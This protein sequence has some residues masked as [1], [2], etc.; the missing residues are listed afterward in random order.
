MVKI[1][2]RTGKT[3][4]Q[5]DKLKLIREDLATKTIAALNAGSAENQASR[6]ARES[7]LPYI[8]LH[9]FPVDHDDVLV[10]PEEDARRLGFACF[11]KKGVNLRI[12]LL[13]PD[14][15]KAKA[16]VQSFAD[17]RKLVPRYYVASQSSIERTWSTYKKH[18]LL[19]VLEAYKIS[20][21]GD[22]LTQFEK[23]FGGLMAIRKGIDDMPT[24]EA[25]QTLLTGAIKFQASDVHFEPE[26][27]QKVRIRYRIDGV[28]QDI[29]RI[30]MHL[31]PLILSRVKMMGKMK[32]N[33][34]DSAQDGRFSIFFNEER[35]DVRVSII[36]GNHGE[37]IVMRLLSQKGTALDVEVLG[38]TGL[39]YE[40]VRK[41]IAK[42]NGLIMTTGPTGSGKTTTLYALLNKLNDTK[43]KIITIEDPIE[44]QIDGISQ[45]EVSKGQAY[46]FAKGLRSI[47][48]QD[49][50][51]ILVGEIRDDETADIAINA[52]LTGHLVLSTL[53]TN[54]A[55]GAIP[56][57]VEMGVKPT[58]IAPAVNAFMA[59][60]LVRQLCKHCKT[61]YEPAKETID[62]LKEILSLISPKA[63]VEVPND[64]KVL[65][66]SNGCDQCNHTG[67]KG[68]IGIFEVL[69]INENIEKL[70]VELGGENDITRVALED[71]MVTM[72]QDGILKAITGITS[73]EE[74]WRV[75]GEGEFLK[76]IYEKLMEQT[77]ARSFTIDTETIQEVEQTMASGKSFEYRTNASNET[78]RRIFASAALSNAGDIHIEPTANT[79]LIRFRM[80]GILHTVAELPLNEYPQIL[81][82][83]KLL[84]ALKSEV[85]AGVKDSRF[86]IRF[87]TVPET[88]GVSSID[89]RVSIILGGYGETV[90]MR[91]LNQGAVALKIDAIGL[92]QENLDRLL[93]AASKSNGLILNTGPTGSGKTTTL[94]SVLQHINSPELKIIT[95]ED[96]IEYQLPG[97]LQTQINE[98]EGYD[99]VSALRALMRQNP[100]I[101]MVGEIRDEETAQAALQASLTGHL[102]ISSLHTNNAAGATPRLLM[103]GVTPDDI[104][105]GAAL[106]MAQ[107]LVRRLCIHCKQPI[108]LTAEQLATIEK[109]LENL[110]PQYKNLTTARNAHKAVGCPECH[111][112]GYKGRIPV[113]ETLVFDRDI[114]DLI[115]RGALAI[116]VQDQAIKSGMM[117]M[118]HDA[119]LRVLEGETPFEE[120][121]RVVE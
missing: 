30:P 96:P 93:I 105:N 1:L 80:D 76:E 23:D 115:A 6:M 81:G 21:T 85:R 61:N 72:T 82:E 35:L 98:E 57:L 40:Q 31:Y 34:R 100:D 90:V 48:R 79:V 117:T 32:I 104:V 27:N 9:I 121:F 84:S 68:R 2:P 49:P 83:I 88:V 108:D 112:T 17:D 55:A 91:L 92:R 103:F 28:L 3:K 8:D 78:L 45:T 38:L 7:G 97:I 59:Q 94:Y 66:Q 99:F 20:L 65:Y 46:T 10:F 86:S 54:N 33:I 5:P 43:T 53:H 69:T 67:Y 62:S 18:T 63:K 74:V 70:I 102:V 58:L 73:L 107:R 26:D 13:H 22:S 110:P 87:E 52:A 16:F 24:T 42:P 111:N 36:P 75:T 11:Q 113:S 15:E 47:V 109:R 51:V 56:R 64:I 12:A 4:H 116:E 118:L 60:R 25:L 106:F 41:A 95:I 37:S 50:D 29:G 44:Y 39:A 89:I 77:L 120:A 114:Q 101:V 119:L 71:G 19:D 14:N